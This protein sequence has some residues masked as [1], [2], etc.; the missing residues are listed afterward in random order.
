MAE[1]IQSEQPIR[2]L[3]DADLRKAADFC[4]LL[5][6]LC[7]KHGRPQAASALGLTAECCRLELE[8][9]AEA[10]TKG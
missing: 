7:R 5:S 6:E 2:Q 1:E 8:L 4:E 9:R 3:S 10:E